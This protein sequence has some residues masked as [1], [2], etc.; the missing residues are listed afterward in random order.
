MLVEMQISGCEPNAATYRMMLDG[1]CRNGDF[2]GGLNVLNAMM[3]SR[4]CPRPD[5][6]N[7]LVV[8]LLKSGNIDGGCFVLEEMVKRKVDFELESWEAVI[9]YA[10][11]EDDNGGGRLRTILSSQPI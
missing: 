3:A 1:L 11:S 9:K 4:H 10:C 6:F 2:E 8:G 5:T 7:C